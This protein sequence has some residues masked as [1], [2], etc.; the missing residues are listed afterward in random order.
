M[1]L[2]PDSIR[3]AMS[4]LSNIGDSDLFPWAAEI[5][6]LKA[7]ESDIIGLLSSTLSIDHLGVTM[8]RQ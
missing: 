4:H 7:F 6:I 2:D 8:D 1:A 5:E 3:W